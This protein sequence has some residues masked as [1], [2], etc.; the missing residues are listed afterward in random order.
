MHNLLAVQLLNVPMPNDEVNQQVS[1]MSFEEV[2][3]WAQASAGPAACT[4]YDL[5]TPAAACSCSP[6]IHSS[7]MGS[8]GPLQLTRARWEFVAQLLCIDPERRLDA[9]SACRL[10]PSAWATATR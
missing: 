8:R 7:W 3:Q 2:A 6:P 9:A 1:R 4:G 10:F 5:L